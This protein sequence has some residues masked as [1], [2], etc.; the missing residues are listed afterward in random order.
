ML[1]L[2]KPDIEAPRF[3]RTRYMVLTTE[4]LKNFKEKYPEY[5]NTS[6]EELKNLIFVHNDLMWRTIIDTR[7]GMELPQSIGNIFIGSCPTPKKYN[8]NYDVV[9]KR[10][11]TSMHRNF[12]SDNYLAK[13]FYTNYGNKYKL[14]HREVWGFEAIRN[15]KRTVSAE[16]PEKWKLYIQIDNYKAI[17]DLFLKHQ[18]KDWAKKEAL[19]KPFTYNEFDMN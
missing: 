1:K 4:L 10:D 7:D 14:K 13:I 8:A 9:I 6:N 16:Y 17:S 12:E 18:R 5:K 19:K 11:I 3:R 15:F 2:K